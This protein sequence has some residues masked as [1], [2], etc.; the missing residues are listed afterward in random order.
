M[1]GNHH[2]PNASTNNSLKRK[3]IFNLGFS[4]TGTTSLE[5]AFQILGHKV[6]RGHWK[7]NYCFYLFALAIAK[8][9]DE[10]TRFTQYF[11][12]FCD[13]PWGGEP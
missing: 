13:A 5:K 9:F 6:A 12:A 8:Q 10:I 3:K 7:Y 1:S 11:D 2:N 4:K